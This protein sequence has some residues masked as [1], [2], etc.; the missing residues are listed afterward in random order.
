MV[1]VYTEKNYDLKTKL[2]IGI[3]TFA[4]WSIEH[5][6]MIKTKKWPTSQRHA[7]TDRLLKCEICLAHSMAYLEINPS[8]PW[9]EPR[10]SQRHDPLVTSRCY[11]FI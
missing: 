9:N 2:K 11:Q 6:A 3:W 1:A 5:F 8:Y 7:E 10:A 4:E